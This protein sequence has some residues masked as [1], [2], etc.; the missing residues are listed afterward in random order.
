MLSNAYYIYHEAFS[1]ERKKLL[2]ELQQL[3]VSPFFPSLPPRLGTPVWEG[4]RAIESLCV[5]LSH[6]YFLFIYLFVTHIMYE[7]VQKRIIQL[8]HML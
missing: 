5:G 8:V 1:V 4:G 7:I 2:A 3:P 6:V